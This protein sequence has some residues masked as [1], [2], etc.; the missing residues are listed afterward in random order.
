[1]A[2]EM[3]TLFPVPTTIHIEKTF[4]MVYGFAN[5]YSYLKIIFKDV[6]KYLI[7]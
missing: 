7:N 2:C 6:R 1:M 3:N 5:F 4:V